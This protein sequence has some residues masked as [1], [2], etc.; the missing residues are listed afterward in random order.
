MSTKYWLEV[1][2]K[3]LEVAS[4]TYSEPFGKMPVIRQAACKRCLCFK[5]ITYVP[6]AK[7]HMCRP[8]HLSY[9][10]VCVI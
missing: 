2:V 10:C 1:R 8:N 9:E 5:Y 6:P 4:I 7:L 3:N